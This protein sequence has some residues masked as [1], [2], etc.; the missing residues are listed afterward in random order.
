MYNHRRANSGRRTTTYSGSR[1]GGRGGFR[2]GY[3]GAQDDLTGAMGRMS[4]T[5]PTVKIP[6]LSS[7]SF[8]PPEQRVAVAGYAVEI[9]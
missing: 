4:L 6:P 7:F 1:R 9:D 2:R 8:G 3:G 5:V